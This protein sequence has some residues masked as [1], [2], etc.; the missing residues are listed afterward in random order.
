MLVLSVPDNG[1]FPRCH[2]LC[3]EIEYFLSCDVVN[4]QSCI[5]GF[6][7]SEFYGCRRVERVRVGFYH[8]K[9]FGYRLFFVDMG[10]GNNISGIFRYSAVGAE[11]DGVVFFDCDGVDFIITE[12]A[13]IPIKCCT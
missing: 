13:L 11:P 3:E 7:Q 1:V 9:R 2:L 8:R 12:T 5:T 6:G 10:N 4:P